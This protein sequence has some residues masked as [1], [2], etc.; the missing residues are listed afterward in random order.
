MTVVPIR[1]PVTIGGSQVADAIGVGWNSPIRIFGELTGKRGFER[2]DSD[3]MWWGN[4]LQ[5]TIFKRLVHEGYDVVEVENRVELHDTQR[6]WLVGHP[7]GYGVNELDGLVVEAKAQAYPHADLSAEVQTLTYM[8]LGGYA[9]GLLA[10][11]R[12]LHLDVREVERVERHIDLILF[13]LDEFWSYVEADE[14][15]PVSGHP[16]DSDALR[17]AYPE[18]VPN[19][20]RRETKEIREARRELKLMREQDGK[21]GA[22]S[23]RKNYLAGLIQA[24]MGEAQTLISLHD[25]PVARWTA[26]MGR[27]FDKARF[28]KDHPRLAAEYTTIDTQRRLTL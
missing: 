22:R 1:P 20:L 13:K 16:D 11:L 5:P 23:R 27:S 9:G 7:D 21:H 18:H 14:W 17:T 4:E 15:P 12:G 8:H 2:D 6:P 3:A 19:K 10:T 26:Y 25:E 24:H 28:E